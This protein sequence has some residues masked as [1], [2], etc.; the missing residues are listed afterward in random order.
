M[1]LVQHHEKYIEVHGYDKIVLMEKGKHGA[2]H[3]RLRKE[4][5]C[6]ISTK[7]LQKISSAARAR[8]LDKRRKVF[9]SA[10]GKN[11]RLRIEIQYNPITDE[12]NVYSSFHGNSGYKLPRIDIT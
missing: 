10:P 4:E 9:Y 11:T 1:V 3:R 7:E 2:L 8:T 12:I 5:K 6:N